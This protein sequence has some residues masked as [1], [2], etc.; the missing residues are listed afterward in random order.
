MYLVL[1]SP[2]PQILHDFGVQ[3]ARLGLLSLPLRG[4]PRG[5]LRVE[6]FYVRIRRA[7]GAT[8]VRGF[9]FICSPFLFPNLS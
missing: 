2:I 8:L 3:F 9:P 4:Q 1:K 7:P 6:G 5:Q